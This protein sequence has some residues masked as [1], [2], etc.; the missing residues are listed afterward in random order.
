MLRFAIGV[1]EIRR[2]LRGFGL[3]PCK[4]DSSSRSGRPF[5]VETGPRLGDGNFVWS[6]QFGVFLVYVE[7]AILFFQSISLRTV[8]GLAGLVVFGL[9][10]VCGLIMYTAA[11]FFAFDRWW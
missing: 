7:S 4:A 5:L 11:T 9:H 2:S 3:N 6:L 8:R 10:V 1:R